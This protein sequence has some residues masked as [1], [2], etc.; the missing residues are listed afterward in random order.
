MTLLHEFQNFITQLLSSGASQ[1]NSV[2]VPFK[3]AQQSK[4]H[5]PK[6]TPLLQDF[7]DWG[8]VLTHLKITSVNLSTSF[9]PSASSTNHRGCGPSWEWLLQLHRTFRA[10]FTVKEGQSPQKNQT[11]WEKKQGFLGAKLQCS[12]IIKHCLR[13]CL[14]ILGQD[15]SCYRARLLNQ[16]THIP[17]VLPQD[18]D[19]DNQW[20]SCFL[21]GSN[22]KSLVQ[23][24]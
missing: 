1:Q 21:L 18:S 6:N 4:I 23:Q 16:H 12:C 7:Q 11:K 20:S 8:I 2:S 24:E 9:W 15:F 13:V 22:G 5:S 3:E 17:C 19:S 10:G 14:E